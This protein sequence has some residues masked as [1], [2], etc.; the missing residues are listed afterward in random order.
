MPSAWKM[1]SSRPVSAWPPNSNVVARQASG[2]CASGNRRDKRSHGNEH[3][4][5]NELPPESSAS[6]PTFTFKCADNERHCG[7]CWGSAYICSAASASQCRSSTTSAVQ[8]WLS[9]IRCMPCNWLLGSGKAVSV[10]LMAWRIR[11]TLAC[12]SSPSLPCS[13]SAT[14][15]LSSTK[16]RLKFLPLPTSK[17]P[18]WLPCN[19]W[20]SPIGLATGTNSI[21]P[22]RAPCCS[23]VVRRF[24]SSHAARIPGNSSA[25]KLAWI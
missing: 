1:A 10:S 19:N 21:T 4:S 15:S 23:S 25:C 8:A 2:I 3:A 16:S 18:W 24:F 11:R 17:R 6:R 14:G 7:Q 22:L 9:R 13:N 12:G 5:S 20:P